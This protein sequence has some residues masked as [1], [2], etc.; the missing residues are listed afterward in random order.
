M[1]SKILIFRTDKI[2]DLLD[3][4]EYGN[5][6]YV[7]CGFSSGVHNVVEPVLQGC[8]VAYGP[9]IKLLDEA[10]KLKEQKLSKI[11]SSSND[12]S[13]FTNISDVD[14]LNKNRSKVFDLFKKNDYQIEKVIEII[15][16]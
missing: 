10:V 5:L 12:F 14:F 1:V 3:L 16:E 2:G 7:G 15:Y 13:D 11:I 6:A 9:N 4:Y 8:Y